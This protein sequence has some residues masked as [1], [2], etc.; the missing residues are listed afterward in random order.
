MNL[1]QFPGFEYY[2]DQLADV[3]EMAQYTM[4][5]SYQD[6]TDSTA[7]YPK[8]TELEYLLLGLTSEVGELAGKVKKEIR[9][10]KIVETEDFLKELGDILWYVAR[11]AAHK[12]V[13]LSDV[14][15]MNIEKLNSR[16]DRGTIGGSGDDR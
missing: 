2:G 15:Q 7:I 14:A 16:K 6:F 5:D 9:D 10:G 1:E 12:D 4:F 11:L 8:E 3:A 13:Y